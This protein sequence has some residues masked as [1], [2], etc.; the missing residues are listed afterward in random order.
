MLS[1]EELEIT[2]TAFKFFRMAR[3]ESGSA[4]QR[5]WEKLNQPPKRKSFLE[6][7][8]EEAKK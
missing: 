5:I 6:K 1:K 7:L 4:L 3:P 2:R 8:K